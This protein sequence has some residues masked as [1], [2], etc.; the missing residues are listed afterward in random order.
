MSKKQPPVIAVD[1]PS[2]TGKGTLCGRL[3][4]NLG[5]H[6]L[7]SG[8]LYRVLGYV[9]RQKNISLDDVESLVEEAKKLDLT[10]EKKG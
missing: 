10:F 7:D 4:V 8:S 3:A 1:G 6:L 5:C 2:G 9:A